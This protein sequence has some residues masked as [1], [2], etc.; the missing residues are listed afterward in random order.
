[1]QRAGI[2]RYVLAAATALTTFLVYL[3]V[4]H[5]EFVNWD[6]YTYVVENSH[7]RSFDWAFF[8]WAFFDFYCFNWHPLTWISH[9]ADYA[10]WGLNPLGHHLTN[11]MLHVANSF[12]VV[13]L[14][15]RILEAVKES[16]PQ[17][18]GRLL[19][20]RMVMLTAGVTGLLF[21]LHPLHVESVAWIAERKDLL[22]ALF[23]LL[24]IT[25]YTKYISSLRSAAGNRRSEISKRR[26]PDDQYPPGRKHYFYAL[27]FFVLALLSKPMAVTLPVVLLILD[28]HPFNR[29]SYF[30]AWRTAVVEK[31]PFLALS[32]GSSVLTILAQRSGGATN[33]MEVV[34]VSIRLLVAVNSLIAYLWKMLLPWDLIPFY[35]YPRE[36][37]I[38][39]AQY[40]VPAV[41][42]LGITITCVAVARKQRAWL[43]AWGYYVVTLLPVL[44]IVQAG[45]QSMADRYTYLPSLGPFF[46]LGLL[47]AFVS[48]KIRSVKRWGLIV[49]AI[50]SL[51]VL[52]VF[53]S[54]SYLTVRQIGIWKDSVSLWNYV[55]AKEPDAARAYYNRGLTFNNRG[56]EFY[57]N[58]QLDRAIADY[59]RAIADY[60]R[61]IGLNP[62]DFETYN[63]RGLAFDRMGQL[64]RAIAD[65][66]KSIARDPTFYRA[67][68]NRGMVFRKM[69][70]L[71]KALEEYTRAIGLNPYYS[72][73]YNNR[74]A[75]FYITNQFDQAIGDYTRAIALNPSNYEAYYNRG[76]AFEKAGQAAKAAEDFVEAS[77]LRSLP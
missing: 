16:S 56:L 65:F 7:I 21:G 35:P 31:L 13:F 27:G 60:D 57:K 75:I 69:G 46:S 50:G 43:S 44:G 52:I 1:M 77:K 55:I 67:Y 40:L 70:L 42:V 29:V 32:L 20:E 59:D 28:W 10:V 34:P 63:N 39:A 38:L 4:L 24:S 71:K 9:A 11:G 26:L 76:L 12:V 6:D 62:P 73:A 68:Y 36:G 49:K 61:A 64:D 74:G 8:K 54:L 58:G 37:S 18:K 45:E 25:A 15:I 14:I 48:T 51:A 66:D 19:T 47:A 2:T 5:N 23:F 53:I 22:C 30:R 41:L 33:L 72:E 17:S 3:P